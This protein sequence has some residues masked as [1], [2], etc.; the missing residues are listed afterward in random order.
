MICLAPSPAGYW[1]PGRMGV[2]EQHQACDG[3]VEGTTVLRVK[4]CS[5]EHCVKIYLI[6]IYSCDL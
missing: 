3:S 2:P 6:F 5:L 4:A 1:A